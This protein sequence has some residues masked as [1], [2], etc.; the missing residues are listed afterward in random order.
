ME[1]RASPLSCGHLCNSV[2]GLRFF[3]SLAGCGFSPSTSIWQIICRCKCYHCYLANWKEGKLQGVI[4]VNCSTLNRCWSRQEQFVSS[5]QLNYCGSS[6]LFPE[7]RMCV[8]DILA[9]LRVAF[10][11]MTAALKKQS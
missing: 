9:V 10:L 5:S 1:F 3:Y 2:T 6:N 4:P 7:N 11:I 8:K